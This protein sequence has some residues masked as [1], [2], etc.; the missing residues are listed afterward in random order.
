MGTRVGRALPALTTGAGTSAA[1]AL[2]TPADVGAGVA[3]PLDPLAVPAGAV[4]DA[5]PAG[6]PAE[7]GAAGGAPIPG[8]GNIMGG[9]APTPPD[10]PAADIG[11]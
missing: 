5:E 1:P 10:A 8:D 6:S 3:P 11:R 9:A 4:T 7:T 2:P